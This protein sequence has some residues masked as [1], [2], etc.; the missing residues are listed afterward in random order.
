MTGSSWAG[1]ITAL[2]TLVTALGGFVVAIKVL[3]PNRRDTQEIHK[4]VNQQRTDMLRFQRALIKT[5]VEHGVK[6]PEDQSLPLED[7]GK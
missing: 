5:L 7:E 3:V 6:V 2:A 1:V 4:I